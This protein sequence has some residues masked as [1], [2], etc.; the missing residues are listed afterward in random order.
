MS[1]DVTSICGPY[2][3][4][5]S[6]NSRHDTSVKPYWPRPTDT[7]GCRFAR[8]R[9]RADVIGQLCRAKQRFKE[10]RDVL[11]ERKA[12][13]ETSLEARNTMIEKL[14]SSAKAQMGDLMLVKEANSSIAEEGTPTKLVHELL[15]S[16]W[17][18]CLI[19]VPNLSFQ[20]VMRGRKISESTVS[21]ANM[22]LIHA[23]PEHLRH[24]FSDEY[25]Q[26]A[27]SADLG[28]AEPSVVASPLYTLVD[29]R[30]VLEE[31][32]PGAGS[33]V[34][35]TMMERSPIESLRRRRWTLSPHYSSTFSTRYRNF[36]TR[37]VVHGQP[38][39]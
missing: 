19:V 35:C 28:L 26:L 39:R 12:A 14:S 5:T 17:K 30:F 1:A 32:I 9:N 33:I 20:V 16:P 22:K 2:P 13:K 25:S 27:W 29:R 15:T 36:I 7:A 37:S 10:I 24:E 6:H 3:L 18:M 23:R 11:A 8:G 21:A 34:V 31:G 4:D 38:H